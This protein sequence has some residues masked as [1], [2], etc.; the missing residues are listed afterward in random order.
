MVLKFHQVR[1]ILS[2]QT[3]DNS[4]SN[5]VAYTQRRPYGAPVFRS[6]ECKT[7]WRYREAGY[8]RWGPPYGWVS[9][10]STHVITTALYRI[11]Y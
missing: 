2:Y 9:R 11:K 3:D 8:A 10:D 1:V 5:N 6:S 4:K 7:I